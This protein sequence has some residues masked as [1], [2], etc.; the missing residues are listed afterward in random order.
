VQARIPESYIDSE[1]LRLEAYQKLSAAAS[2]TASDDAIEHVIDEL[3]DR[4]GEPPADVEGL[5]AIARLRRRAGQA[6]LADVVAMG[7]NLRI[8]P[9]NLPDS[10]RVRLQR[11][12]PKAKL[13]A[14]G[15]AMIVPLPAAGGEPLRDGELIA[16]VAQLLDQLW[17]EKKPEAAPAADA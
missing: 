8:A 9:A 10:M 7:P 16:W 4:Y 3:T 11:L 15:E 2:V 6:G 17:P 13:V 12:H 5:L 14:G 1:R